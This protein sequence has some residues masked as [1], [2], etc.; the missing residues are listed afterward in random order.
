MNQLTLHINNKL[1]AAL[2]AE[3]AGLST[4]YQIVDIANLG[5]KKSNVSQV[6]KLP[7]TPEL[8]QALGFPENYNS[9]DAANQKQSIIGELKEN[10]ETIISGLIKFKGTI[11]L[12][13]KVYYQLSI[14]GDSA[15]WA[16][17]LNDKKLRHLDLWNYTHLWTQ[18]V[19][20][21]SEIPSTLPYVYPL[22]DNGG[23]GLF[24]VHEAALGN[25]NSVR[26]II[27]GEIFPNDF[28]NQSITVFGFESS[29]Y[30]QVFEDGDYSVDNLYDG[31]NSR[32]TLLNTT[33][34]SYDVVPEY[35][36]IQ[37]N[38]TSGIRVR[39]TDRYPMIRESFLIEKIFNEIGYRVESN[40]LTTVLSKKYTVHEANKGWQGQERFN[41]FAVFRV[42][43]IEDVVFPGSPSGYTDYTFPFDNKTFGSH[44]DNG[45]FFDTNDYHYKPKVATRQDFDFA[46]TFQVNGSLTLSVWVET[47]TQFFKIVTLQNFST[48][49]HT[50]ESTLSTFVNVSETDE[51]R[52]RVRIQNAT[53]PVTFK[54]GNCFFWN[55]IRFE[56]K[57]EGEDIH[58]VEHLPDESQLAYVQAIVKRDGLI[59]MTDAN[60]KT[61]Y[62]EDYDGFIDKSNIID[63]TD[64]TDVSQPIESVEV[65]ENPPKGIWYKYN[66]DSDDVNLKRLSEVFNIEYGSFKFDYKNI[67]KGTDYTE[68][69][70]D[71]F[72]ATL[73]QSASSIGIN[74]NVPIIELENYGDLHQTRVLYYNGRSN[75]G[76]D[77]W[78][79]GNNVR[80]QAPIPFFIKDTIKNDKSLHYENGVL[81]TGLANR[82]FGTLH[83]EIDES[84]YFTIFLNLNAFDISHF[85]NI[86]NEL[87]RDFRAVFK[88]QTA[89]GTYLC[90][91]VKIENYQSSST[92]STKCHFIKLTDVYFDNNEG[93]VTAPQDVEFQDN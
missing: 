44:F 23:L 50:L 10:G 35:G 64:K 38:K 25:G 89:K 86:D 70:N 45:N 42:G 57:K 17:E 20:E 54:K 65:L 31:V 72:S 13:Q 29:E 67:F 36:Y 80:S 69:T 15:I 77:T 14:V 41:N 56:P 24:Y 47:D 16:N 92:S 53:N 26:M 33:F 39:V 5:E 85:V 62:I 28:T 18:T 76:N 2:E 19:Q 75:L 73:E 90:R 52:V 51:V 88:I 32:I 78:T 7:A 22:I 9:I 11:I 71:L 34:Q 68:Y 58:L 37:I 27:K 91:L 93:E 74:I 30:N 4:D 79:Q 1:V 55:E 83:K 40:Y 49:T 82:N 81:T 63:W 46:F 84:I 12:N 3:N 60:T 43:I 48:G 87:K 8:K 59:V 21:A 66:N 61:V 6:F